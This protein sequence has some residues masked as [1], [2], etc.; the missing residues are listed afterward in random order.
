V[1]ERGSKWDE[2]VVEER[3]GEL[4]W[5]IENIELDILF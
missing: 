5:E 1:K 2:C 3:R 4:E